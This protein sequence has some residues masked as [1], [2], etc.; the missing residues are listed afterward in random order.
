MNCLANSPF[1]VNM[2]LRVNMEYEG[3]MPLTET[4]RKVLILRVKNTSVYF[5]YPIEAYVYESNNSVTTVN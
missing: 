3:V 5:Y 4:I 2:Q 1:N